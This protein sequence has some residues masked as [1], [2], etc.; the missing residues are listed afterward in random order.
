[1]AARPSPGSKGPGLG[2]LIRQSE[3]RAK[4]WYV[5]GRQEL[6][7]RREKKQNASVATPVEK[8]FSETNA[9]KRNVLLLS[10][11]FFFFLEK[12]FWKNDLLMFIKLLLNEGHSG[13]VGNSRPEHAHSP[14]IVRR[15]GECAGVGGGGRGGREGIFTSFG[16]GGE[17]VQGSHTPT[18]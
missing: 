1:M 17:R 6:K 15:E 5:D 2:G 16:G 8:H 3:G 4:R 7:E 9:E 10:L 13:A 14:D 11:G 18:R 12:R